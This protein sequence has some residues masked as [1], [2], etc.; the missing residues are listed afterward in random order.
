M[1]F[2]G[3][4]TFDFGKEA[5]FCSLSSDLVQEAAS[6]PVSSASEKEDSSSQRGTPI[7]LS[8][9][10]SSPVF[11]DDSMRINIVKASPSPQSIVCYSVTP[12]PLNQSGV[13]NTELRQIT[14][15]EFMVLLGLINPFNIT[16]LSPV[17]ENDDVYMLIRE[18][19]RPTKII[20]LGKHQGSISDIHAEQLI[21][22]G[23]LERYKQ[24]DLS[25]LT[26]MLVHIG[27][28]KFAC[29]TCDEVKSQFPAV[30]FT[31]RS[32]VSFPCV[33]NLKSQPEQFFQVQEYDEKSC[34]T[35]RSTTPKPAKLRRPKTPQAS[36]S[37]SSREC[38][39]GRKQ[40]QEQA[41]FTAGPVSPMLSPASKK[42]K[43]H[44]NLPLTE[45]RLAAGVEHME[46]FSNPQNSSSAKK[47]L[48]FSG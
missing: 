4:N 22:V 44:Q 30:V 21:M 20:S 38:M 42:A 27:L 10:A 40:I 28:S 15:E 31:G 48:G 35:L 24:A 23:Y 7:P 26:T 43:F 17:L 46:I 47:S 16:Y 45:L 32:Q 14:S 19:C 5:S 12:T 3:S 18:D 13:E 6:T 29:S 2:D 36:V 34:S 39:W 9:R 33:V 11:I 41:G 37:C 25:S 1:A 8:N